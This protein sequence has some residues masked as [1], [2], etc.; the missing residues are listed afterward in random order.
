MMIIDESNCQMIVQDPFF[1]PED[2]VPFDEREMTSC[3]KSPQDLKETSNGYSVIL[4]DSTEDENSS[5]GNLSNFIASHSST[6]LSEDMSSHESQYLRDFRATKRKETTE[7]K[8]KG[9][10]TK[11]FL[12]NFKTQQISYIKCHTDK[13]LFNSCALI[14]KILK[15][16]GINMK[17]YEELYNV[18]AF[19]PALE[20]YFASR[21]IYRDL[22]VSRV[23][24]HFKR[25]YS[26]KLHVFEEAFKARRFEHIN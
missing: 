16:N 21:Q 19:R 22:I 10:P 25:I 18:E 17:D 4:D 13:E 6:N 5:M 20:K 15:K 3:K 14:T 2:S 24:Q 23:S 12:S 7:E 1:D 26:R 9:Y 8:R 11:N